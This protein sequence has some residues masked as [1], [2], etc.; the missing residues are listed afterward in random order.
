MGSV[1]RLFDVFGAFGDGVALALPVVVVV[2]LGTLV[3]IAR[4]RHDRQ[5]V[6]TL[7]GGT[8]LASLVVIAATTLLPVVVGAEATVNLQPGET[9]ENYLSFGDDL[10]SARNLGLNIALFVPFGVGL[11]L[12]RRWGIGRVLPVG[13]VLSVA[14]EAVQYM[15]PLGRATDVDDVVLNAIGT[16]LG[17]LTVSVLRALAPRRPERP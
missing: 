7:G 3:G 17:A 9:I 11:A 10:L 8:L 16:A 5:W 13:I 1:D 14:L 12:W 6:R 4:R 15:L 2:A